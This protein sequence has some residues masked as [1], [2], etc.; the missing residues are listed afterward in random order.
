MAWQI[1]LAVFEG[2]LEDLPGRRHRDRAVDALGAAAVGR[3]AELGALLDPNLRGAAH[4][5]LGQVEAGPGNR[6]VVGGAAGLLRLVAV[7]VV[8]PRDGADLAQRVRAGLR[9][10]DWGGAVLVGTRDEPRDRLA[11][12]AA[13]LVAQRIEGLAQQHL[14]VDRAGEAG[15]G[16]RGQA[17]AAVVDELLLEI[18]GL[19][20]A[21][22]VEVQRL[23]CAGL[24][25][26]VEVVGVGEVLV[27]EAGNGAGDLDRQYAADAS[28]VKS[29]SSISTGN[30][31]RA[32]QHLAM[33]QRIAGSQMSG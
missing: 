21:G 24:E 28:T 3:A 14:G 32:S 31:F 23:V 10:A 16:S 27:L 11:A 15:A 29:Q 25:V 5:L 17:V 12:G 20:H 9:A 26:A 19:G 4:D 2:G 13:G 18:V 8:A 22:D 30:Q 6:A 7:G 33:R 1:G